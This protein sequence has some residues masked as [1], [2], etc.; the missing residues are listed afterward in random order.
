[1][2]NLK[3]I[4]G[5]DE[6]DDLES[7][8]L[9]ALQSLKRKNDSMNSNTHQYSP[10]KANHYRSPLGGRSKRGRFFGLH[11]GRGGK[12]GHFNRVR[13]T[14]LISITPI[15]EDTNVE[16]K[17]TEPG[18]LTL[19]QDRYCKTSDEK[20][21]AEEGT[22]KFNRYNNSDKSESESD[23]EDN[24]SEDEVLGGE[25][26]RADSLEA[27]MQELD[28]EIQGKPKSKE[29]NEVTEDKP[30]TKRN[31][32]K[33]KST[34]D[35][36]CKNPES[37]VKKEESEK[38]AEVTQQDNSDIKKFDEEVKERVDSGAPIS[39]RI[40]PQK[41]F[42]P[43][44]VPAPIERYNRSPF[45][46]RGFHNRPNHRHYTNHAPPPP[47][48]HMQ[49]G[50]PPNHFMP[51]MMH[52]P[53]QQFNPM[54]MPP[55]IIPPQ[56]P[57]FL[58]RPLSPLAINTESLTTATLAPLS[59]RSAAFVLQNKAIIERR[60]RSPRRSYSRSHSRSP[61]R[62]PRRSLTPVK[63]FPRRSISPRRSP[64]RFSPRRRSMS[65]KRRSVSPRRGNAAKTSDVSPRNRPRMRERTVA[66]KS[67]NSGDA[68][69]VAPKEKE[70]APPT[71]EKPLDPVLEARRRKFESNEIGR[72]GIIRLKPK[73][74]KPVDPPPKDSIVAE[75][76]PA[77]P[78]DKSKEL[79]EKSSERKEKPV[80]LKEKVEK[81]AQ[82]K[83]A[84]PKEKPAQPKEKSKDDAKDPDE[85]KE[86]ER[87][88]NED[89]LLDGDEITLDHKVEDIFSDDDSASDNEGR[90][91]VKQKPGEKV[92]VL[93]FT[94]LVNGAKEE[95]K[96]EALSDFRRDNRDKGRSNSR[97]NER[98]HRARSPADRGESR[99]RDTLRDSKE[100]PTL[101]KTESHEKPQV[102]QRVMLKSE[103]QAPVM[104]KRFERKIEIKI[105]NPSKYEK[106]GKS[107]TTTTKDDDKSKIEKRDVIESD[108]EVTVEVE[109]EED[110]TKPEVDRES[111]DEENSVVNEGGDL[112]AQ[113]SRKRAEKL[114][115]IPVGEVSSRLLQFALQG[116]VFKKSKKKSKDKSIS[117]SDGKLPIHLRLGL[118]DHADIFQDVK[119]KK[120]TRKR[121]NREVLEQV[122]YL[123]LR[124]TYISTVS[125]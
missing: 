21:L 37:K 42:V 56:L 97:Y 50:P 47:P 115:K 22:S 77:Q 84:Q 101:K 26:K 16:D 1:M 10:D 83:S 66:S 33:R 78:N 105:K 87:L 24:T 38:T 86:L 125:M 70:T 123:L 90:F 106:S 102:R 19:P 92:P 69:A 11:Q 79:K 14:N 31:K 114:H 122:Y 17:T 20:Q 111:E 75:E 121:K 73:E 46:R 61:S 116:A 104:D 35:S 65:P 45:S 85:F 41:E 71:E 23:R 54:F 120:K 112:R 51:H 48:L 15:S 63:R 6:E 82:E 98:R 119:V 39:S 113:L 44:D 88:L 96:S 81:P 7:L 57:P 30:K 95:I 29:D 60:R 103:R 108:D 117:N 76:K 36:D 28:D 40:S 99:R 91:K 27:L 94:K 32:K 49:Y 13:N 3:K 72:K 12:T 80:Q 110:E 74:D 4:T 107:R 124:H 9:A 89:A 8:R 53:N 55:G 118:A 100:K 25:L 18:A 64:R 5:S 109:D 93:P 52:H 68:A 2:N 43:K 67:G 62:S 58:E 34:S 59:P